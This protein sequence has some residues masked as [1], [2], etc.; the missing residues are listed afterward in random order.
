MEIRVH[1]VP[2]PNGDRIIGAHRGDPNV[3]VKLWHTLAADVSQ[4]RVLDVGAND[5]Y[6]SV[7]ALLA[8]AADVTAINTADC[9][10]FPA[11]I[12]FIA[13]RWN[14]SPQIVVADFLTYPFDAT[15]DVILF[16]GVLYHLENVFA[17][18]Q[19]LRKILSPNGMLYIETQMSQIDSPLPLFETA[20]DIFPT[21]A[22]QNKEALAYVGVSNFLFP[23]EA[24]MRNLAHSYDFTCERLEGIYT[25]D[26]SS[27]GVFKLKPGPSATEG[28]AARSCVEKLKRKIA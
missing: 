26:Y 2:L 16:L 14:V 19:R 11:K 27:R 24:C 6:Y 21:I 28:G 18:M 12:S 1:S 3:Q 5:G 17:A 25:R 13:K 9:P 20:S 10:G 23:N 7:A 22:E 15:Y 8:G 4:K